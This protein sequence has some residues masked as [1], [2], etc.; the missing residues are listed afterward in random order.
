MR[1]ADASP[2]DAL[3]VMLADT[4]ACGHVRAGSVAAERLPLWLTDYASVS[5][6]SLQSTT[7]LQLH[8][9]PCCIERT[10]VRDNG[11]H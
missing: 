5:G 4:S 11:R 6:V 3:G 9:A 8:T 10:L 1:R 7:A 2:A